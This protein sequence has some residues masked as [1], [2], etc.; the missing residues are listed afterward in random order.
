MKIK[1]SIIKD[2]KLLGFY[3]FVFK[4]ENSKIMGAILT[5]YHGVIGKM[6]IEFNI[7]RMGENQWAQINA[8]AEGKINIWAIF[9]YAHILLNEGL[10]LN[11]INSQILNIILDAS[12]DNYGQ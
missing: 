11:P 7:S 10:F 8:N 5:P 3:G 1:N 6:I 2:N 4:A 12:G 9:W